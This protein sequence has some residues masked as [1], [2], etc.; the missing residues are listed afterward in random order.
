[1]VSQA[2]TE[3]NIN[4]GRELSPIANLFRIGRE[5]SYVTYGDI[6]RFVPYPEQDL[7]YVDRIFA[8]LMSAGIPFGEDEDHLV[9][10]DGLVDKPD[11]YL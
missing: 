2:V 5:Q 4:G 6:L 10:I 1:M 11:M 8:C 9:N 7:D 3:K